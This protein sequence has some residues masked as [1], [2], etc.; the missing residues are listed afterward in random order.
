MNKWLYHRLCLQC[1]KNGLGLGRSNPNMFSL[2]R[3][4]W[5]H[6]RGTWGWSLSVLLYAVLTLGINNESQEKCKSVFPICTHTHSC[7]YIA[8]RMHEFFCVVIHKP[9]AR[10]TLSYLEN[11]ELQ[12]PAG[13]EPDRKNSCGKH[14]PTTTEITHTVLTLSPL[15]FSFCC[16]SAISS[17]FSLLF[18]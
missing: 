16:W 8:T 13:E 17:S 6:S 15:L 7:M 4:Y 14:G 9:V 18:C 12:S 5:V 1:Q 2:S 3:C 11:A 10:A